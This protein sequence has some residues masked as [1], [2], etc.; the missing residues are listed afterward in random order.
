MLG[1]IIG[2]TESISRLLTTCIVNVL[3]IV[4]FCLRYGPRVLV[5]F[6]L[7]QAAKVQRESRDVALHFLL[8]R[9]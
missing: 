5:R 7:E 9:R 3:F 8:P 6:T 2:R 4:L 1:K